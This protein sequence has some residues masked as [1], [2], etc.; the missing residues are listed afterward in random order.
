MK[1]TSKVVSNFWGA[2][3]R[4][5]FSCSPVVFFALFLILVDARSLRKTAF[6]SSVMQV[7]C[8]TSLTDGGVGAICTGLTAHTGNRAF[9]LCRIIHPAIRSF[10]PYGVH[11]GKFLPPVRWRLPTIRGGQGSWGLFRRGKLCRRHP[12]DRGRRPHDRL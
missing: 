2:H 1:Y 5:N 7:K 12:P 6:C 3:Q 11:G 10:P 9:P 8:M 4:L